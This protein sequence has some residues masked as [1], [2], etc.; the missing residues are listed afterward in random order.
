MGGGGG[1]R[2]LGNISGYKGEG[3]FTLYGILAV[4]DGTWRYWDGMEGRAGIALY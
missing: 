1:E 4:S 2:A 3:G